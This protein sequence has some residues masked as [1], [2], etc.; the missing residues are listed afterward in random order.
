MQ[1]A[2]EKRIDQ[3]LTEVDS[4]TADYQLRLAEYHRNARYNPEGDK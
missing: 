2:N 4:S 3:V 1:S